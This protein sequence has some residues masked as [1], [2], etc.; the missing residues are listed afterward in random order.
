MCLR[1]AIVGRTSQRSTGQARQP[2]G[3]RQEQQTTTTPILDDRSPTSSGN[4]SDDSSD[5]EMPMPI[6]A[7]AAKSATQEFKSETATTSS[8]SSAAATAAASSAKPMPTALNYQTE[9]GPSTSSAASVSATAA[10]S[11]SDNKYVYPATSF[12]NI[13]PDMLRQLIQ[14]GQLQVHAEEDGNQYVTIPLSST[15]AS[16]IKGKSAAAVTVNNTTTQNP[17]SE[18]NTEKTLSIKQEYD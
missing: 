16:Y 13:P 8:S 17:K 4:E 7:E 3:R 14:S 15:V 5:V 11:S 18:K 9:S 12:A 2:A 6:D 1:G 10:A